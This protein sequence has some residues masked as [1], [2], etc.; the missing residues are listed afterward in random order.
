MHPMVKRLALLIFATSALLL[1]WSGSLY[2]GLI[3]W[4]AGLFGVVWI[5]KRHIERR[6]SGILPKLYVCAKPEEYLEWLGDLEKEIVFRQ[7]LKEKISV[8]KASGWL[9]QINRPHLEEVPMSDWKKEPVKLRDPLK[10]AEKHLL[11]PADRYRKELN[12]MYRL[13]IEGGGGFKD[14]KPVE[15]K[16]RIQEGENKIADD[17]P[18][19][20]VLL[21]IG[22][23]IYSKWLL[24][25]QYRKEAEQQL[26]EL[27]ETEVFN[28]MFGEVNY[29]LGQIEIQKKQKVKAEY[30]YRVAMNFADGTALEALMSTEKDRE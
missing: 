15:L 30:Y 22:K 16:A 2:Q 24:G 18:Q 28:L 25:H 7:L 19:K 5:D 6:L 10:I 17:D 20:T 26:T 3:L 29:H 9:Y 11:T 4:M 21:L 1:V 13:W 27:R 14:I 23:L 8:Y 12:Q